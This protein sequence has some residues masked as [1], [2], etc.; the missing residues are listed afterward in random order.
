MPMVYASFVGLM[1][2]VVANLAL[3]PPYGIVGA[4]IATPIG[5]AMFLVSM[6]IWTR[7]YARWRVPWPTVGRAGVAACVGAAAGWAALSVSHISGVKIL[8]SFVACIGAYLVLL[9]LLG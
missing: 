8:A 4:A 1:A 2:N 3:I 9:E 5:T 6:Q 7:Q